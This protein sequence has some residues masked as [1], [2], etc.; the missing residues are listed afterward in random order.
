MVRAFVPT[1]LEEAM[2][3]TIG[4]FGRLGLSILMLL[5]AVTFIERRRAAGKLPEPEYSFRGVWQVVGGGILIAAVLTGLIYVW[6]GSSEHAIG[7]GGIMIGVVLIG[8]LRGFF[9]EYQQQR[10]GGKKL[11]KQ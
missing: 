8:S 4:D 7:L 11:D 10:R 2:T 3:W 1:T 6:T 9:S 5:A